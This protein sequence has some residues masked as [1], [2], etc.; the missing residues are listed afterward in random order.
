[1]NRGEIMNKDF[2][3]KYI[4]LV[5]FLNIEISWIDRNYAYHAITTHEYLVYRYFHN[6]LSSKQ[7]IRIYKDRV[8]IR[9]RIKFRNPIVFVED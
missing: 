5:P 2:W 4:L 3:F 6:T 9:W 7:T 8:V 1:M